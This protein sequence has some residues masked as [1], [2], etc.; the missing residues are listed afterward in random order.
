M[1]FHPCPLLL[2]IC[3]AFSS[4][5]CEIDAMGNWWEKPYIFHGLNGKATHFP[6]GKGYHRTRIWWK[7]VLSEE[8][9]YHFPRLSQFDGLCCIFQCYGKLM[10]NLSISHVMKYIRGWESDW[11]NASILWEKYEYQFPRLSP[12][13]GF[14]TFSRAMGNWWENPHISHMISY[15]RGW[16]SNGKKRPYC[17]KIMGTNFPV[18]QIWWILLSFL[19]LLETD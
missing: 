12:Y 4:S 11:R 17:G 2:L 18:S 7:K 16:E 9:G 1:K 5:V 10:G 6:W 14:V 15:A 19:M 13:D 3:L 8:Y